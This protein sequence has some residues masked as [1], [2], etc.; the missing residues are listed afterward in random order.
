MF[1]VEIW[2]FSSDFY[3]VLEFSLKCRNGKL[4][5]I[6]RLF[7]HICSKFLHRYV[8]QRIREFWYQVIK[9]PFEWYPILSQLAM[10]YVDTLPTAIYIFVKALL[11]ELPMQIFQRNFLLLQKNPCIFMAKRG[12]W[13]M[14]M[15]F[16]QYQNIHYCNT[17]KYPAIT[18]RIQHSTRV[19]FENTVLC[20]VEKLYF[21]LR[22]FITDAKK[23][24]FFSRCYD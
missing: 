8:L 19:T 13:P 15:Y 9:A 24:L 21:F 20:Q 10:K 17:I 14:N 11:V 18:S 1:S 3:G 16:A 23:K 4:I 7:I 5:Y 12:L 2:Q 22:L 6:L